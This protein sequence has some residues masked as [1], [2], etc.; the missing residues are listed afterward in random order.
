M[1]NLGRIFIVALLLLALPA[2]AAFAQSSDGTVTVLHGIP[3][4]GGFPVDI[5]VNGDY[6]APFIPGLTFAEF[7]GPV[8]STYIGYYYQRLAEDADLRNAPSD[9]PS[10]R[11]ARKC[12]RT[13]ASSIHPVIRA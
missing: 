3:G 9:H 11:A 2:G 13:R 4:D 8:T 1:R 5:Y 6:S 12:W 10:A 7:A